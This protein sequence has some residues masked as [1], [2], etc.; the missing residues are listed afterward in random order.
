[1][2]KFVSPFPFK[3]ISYNT[4]YITAGKFRLVLNS[5]LFCLLIM[6]ELYVG[7]IGNSF[8]LDVLNFHREKVIV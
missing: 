7:D 6:V 3:L 5:D 4:K 8:D 2:R 1:M